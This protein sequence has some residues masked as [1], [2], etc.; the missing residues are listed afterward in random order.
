MPAMLLGSFVEINLE[1]MTATLEAFSKRGFCGDLSFTIKNRQPFRVVS[2]VHHPD[3]K[4]PAD[5]HAIV[6]ETRPIIKQWL[7]LPET[8]LTVRFNEG[9]INKVQLRDHAAGGVEA[10]S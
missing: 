7:T 6:D 1:I 9:R 2:E 3:P 8:V 10:V 4:N 5:W